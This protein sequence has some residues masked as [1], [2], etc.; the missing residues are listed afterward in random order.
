MPLLLLNKLA[1][2]D[3]TKTLKNIVLYQVLA[4]DVRCGKSLPKEK[5]L[6]FFDPSGSALDNSQARL[7]A[8][9]L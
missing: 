8:G 2:C 6:S 3:C 9:A 5:L 4:P 7:I 1:A